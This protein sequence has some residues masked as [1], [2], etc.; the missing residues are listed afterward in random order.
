MRN[1]I[2]AVKE[3][4]KYHMWND[5]VPVAPRWLDI[6]FTYFNKNKDLSTV[7]FLQRVWW[8]RSVTVL[9]CDESKHAPSTAPTVSRA[10]DGTSDIFQSLLL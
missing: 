8:F 5:H 7:A 2:E 9:Y 1:Q 4:C 3:E 10:W 6:H